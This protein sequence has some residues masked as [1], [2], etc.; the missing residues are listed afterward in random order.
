MT[1]R[2]HFAAALLIEIIGAAAVLLVATR[3][4]QTITT[5]RARPFTDDVLHVSGRSI[6][7]APTALALVALAGVV[8]VLA[9]KGVVRQVIG[10]LVVA[11]GVAIVWRSSAALPAVGPDRAAA[12]V[13]AKH[14]LAAGSEVVGRHVTT[15]PVW[16]ALSITAGVLVMVAG[17]LIAWRGARWGAM[18]AR[19][20]VPAAR[21]DT[22][23]DERA[24]ARADATMWTAME[25][26]EDPTADDPT[27]RQ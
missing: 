14:Q 20:E 12:L 6:D 10:V 4:W 5:L 26:G 16:G 9:T 23:D 11:A 17:A 8:A 22:D 15:A 2:A 18:S 7:N 19:Y 27:D 25:R 3:P 24:R 1:H 13:R 21:L